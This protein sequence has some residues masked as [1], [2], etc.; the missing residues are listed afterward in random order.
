MDWGLAGLASRA[1]VIPFVLDPTIVVAAFGFSAAVGVLF[2]F[3]PARRVA[4]LIPIDAL[5]HE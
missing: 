1:M 2:G 4:R 5:R 3:I